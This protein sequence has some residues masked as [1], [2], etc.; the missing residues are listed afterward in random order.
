MRNKLSVILAASLFAFSPRPSLGQQGPQNDAV[1][2]RRLEAI[3]SQLRQ[4]RE[5]ERELAQTEEDLDRARL[6]GGTVFVLS[7]AALLALAASYRYA[8]ESPRRLFNIFPRIGR[9]FARKSATETAAEAAA[10]ETEASAASA[11]QAGDQPIYVEPSGQAN[12][13]GAKPDETATTPS[14]ASSRVISNLR[15]A[16][17]LGSSVAAGGSALYVGGK[18]LVLKNEIERNRAILAQERR[19]LEELYNTADL[20]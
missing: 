14:Q 12:P 5:N 8:G 6:Q 20:R 13:P 11:A 10:T 18:W 4:I 7:S 17:M 9:I 2:K 19:D 15:H 3:V 1:Q 16:G